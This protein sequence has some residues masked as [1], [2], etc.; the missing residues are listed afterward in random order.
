MFRSRLFLRMFVLV[1]PVILVFSVGLYV[2]SV[3]LIK[4]TAYEIEKNAGRT[5]LNNV[6]ELTM[7]IQLNLERHRMVAVNAHQ[8]Q[9][10]NVITLAEAYGRQ[11]MADADAGLLS[12]EDAKLKFL[13]GLRSF[14][15]GNNDY[16]WVA[17]YNAKL[18][19]HPDPDFHGINAADIRDERERE[20]VRELVRLAQKNGEGYRVYY[21]RRL[22]ET[23]ETE[24]ISYY[25]DFPE[26]GFVMGT[27]VYLD[28]I[29]QEVEARR[30]EA[31]AEL[32]RLMNDIKLAKTGYLYI[33]DSDFNMLIHPNPNIEG[34]NFG[35][36]RDTLTGKLIG[37]QLASVAGDP[38]GLVY[39][40][41]K[42]SDPGQYKYD[43]V[44]WV[45][46]FEAFDWYIA[47]SVYTDELQRSS[48]I[49]GNRI[50]FISVVGLVLAA[51]LMLIFIRHLTAPIFKLAQTASRVQDGDLHAQSN[52]VRDD[53]FGTLS[54]AFDSMIRQVRDNIDTLDNKVHARTVELE[55][56]NL[57]LTSAIE[58]KE[59]ASQELSLSERRQRLILDAI[60]GFIVYFDSNMRLQFANRAFVKFMGSTLENLIGKVCKE[61][62]SSAFYTIAKP[63]LD[64][65]VSGSAV[66]FE[67]DLERVH[68]QAAIC[69]NTLIPEFSSDGHVVGLY[70]LSMDITEEKQ[71]E[72]KLMEAQR[73]SA[74]GQL[75]GGLAH[76]FNNLL[77]IIIGNLSTLRD[78]FGDDK[79]IDGYLEPALRAG[80]R[81]ADITNRLLAFS[82]KQ[83]LR[84]SVVDL[85]V[86]TPDVM[87]LLKNSLPDN[88]IIESE[89][90]ESGCDI[91]ADPNQ[92]ENALVNLALNA[93]DAMSQGGTLTFRAGPWDGEHGGDF[94][95]PV[96]SGEFGAITVGDTGEGF[97]EFV[98]ARA[99]E[100][101][102][103]TK[104]DSGGTGLGLSMVY[105]FVKQSK[106]YLR[107]TSKRGIKT[108]ITLLLP[109]ALS[110][111][112][113]YDSLRTA[114]SAIDSIGLGKL[115]LLV[116]DDDDVRK[117]VRRQLRELGFT[118]LE[119]SNA[120]EAIC[121]VENVKDLFLLVTDIVMAEGINGFELSRQSQELRPELHVLLMTGY[122]PYMENI[123]NDDGAFLILRKPFDVDELGVAIR[124]AIG[125][126]ESGEG[127]HANR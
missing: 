90:L 82:R 32:R 31:F 43:K 54:R 78:K 75:S 119:A 73:M 115:V 67:S 50:L 24:K 61:T 8:R 26:W 79:A 120:A 118:I 110:N 38:D 89:Y 77:S 71:A 70:F 66:S 122:S 104:K 93:R 84:P 15:Y 117:V 95:E 96:R 27:G 74:T 41:D 105:G 7:R 44:A 62:M 33:F 124:Q 92:L 23:T 40:W 100:P 53:E 126:D 14:Q 112:L 121:L 94:D 36:L 69:K 102:F 4:A 49:L 106:G 47:S 127:S 45:R 63:F 109:R 60:P 12:H 114:S 34:T 83:P 22:G 48:H 17:D 59:Q 111:D 35:A 51:L 65:A 88:I 20:T 9:L 85:N 39:K 116:E 11:V 68:G 29:T 5:I 3:P 97:S 6:F 21:W 86:F 13:N 16:I 55:E 123:D 108:E 2:F 76:D 57:H 125:A 37:E 80:R 64:E 98:L 28:D 91:F 1:M 19:S 52:L 72:I 113:Q 87:S 10:K 99:F 30:L 58:S 56:A 103:S 107:V 46:H 101:F 18:V 81:G 42:P 25:R